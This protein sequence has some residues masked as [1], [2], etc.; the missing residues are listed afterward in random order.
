MYPMTGK[1]LEG[2]K[3]LL[4]IRGGGGGLQKGPKLEQQRLESGDILSLL[5]ALGT[6]PFCCDSA[7]TGSSMCSSL[8]LQSTEY[9][10]SVVA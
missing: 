10:V 5:L 7:E 1:L 4:G 3:D 9:G 8:Y 2:P 6:S